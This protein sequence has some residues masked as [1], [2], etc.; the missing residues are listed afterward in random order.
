MVDAHHEIAE[1]DLN[2]VIAG[3]D[4]AL[5]V[6]YRIRLQSPPP[7]RPWPRTWR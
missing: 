1:M 5:G 4:G 3:A 6:D 7:R 2:P